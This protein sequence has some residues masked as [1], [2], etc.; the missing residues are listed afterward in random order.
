MTDAQL[1]RL[2]PTVGGGVCAMSLAKRLKLP[3]AEVAEV[4]TQ[5]KQLAERH[6]IKRIGVYYW[7]RA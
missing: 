2:I 3:V 4:A 6:A 1:V 7:G 5:L